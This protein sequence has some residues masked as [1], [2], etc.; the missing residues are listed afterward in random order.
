MT[1]KLAVILAGP[2]ASGKSAAA[3][4]IAR[5]LDGVVINAD[6]MQLYDTLRVVT[7]RPDDTALAAAPHRLYGVLPADRP[8]S[9]A[10]WRD[11]AL[12]EIEACGDRLPILVGGT[13]LYLRALL[14]GLVDLPAVSADLRAAATARRQDLGADAF[15][16]EIAGFDPASAAR[17]PP[18]DTQRLI[19]AWEMFH[20]TGIPFSRWIAETDTPPPA[21][22]AFVPII[23]DPPRAV[24]YQRIDQRVEQMIA[25]GA[26][27]E[28]S[29]LSDADPAWPIMKA[30]G[31]RELLSH[32][33]GAVD[34]AAAIAAAQQSTR[35]YAKRQTTW[36]RHQIPGS[37]RF[38]QENDPDWGKIIAFM[39]QAHLTSSD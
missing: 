27:A 32:L 1:R 11:A 7:A 33:H 12:A 14:R 35:N 31:V 30:V 25:A 23:L 10:W 17:L 5:A 9:A 6:S 8:A 13:G 21:H 29:C 20:A 38:A 2:T 26:L 24:L 28:L 16:A 39:R 3:L 19:R 36:F 15:H 18:G 22:L 34:L 4:A 37:V